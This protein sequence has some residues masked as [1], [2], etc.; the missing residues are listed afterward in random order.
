MGERSPSW[1]YTSTGMPAFT[2]TGSL[3]SLTASRGQEQVLPQT[4][5]GT[6]LDGAD[7]ARRGLELGPYR[8]AGLP[9]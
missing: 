1:T 5:G 8:S 9:P 2:G 4:R 3:L 6:C 7:L